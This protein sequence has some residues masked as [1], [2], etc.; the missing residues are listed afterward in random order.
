LK[1]SN[2]F[3]SSEGGLLALFSA[4]GGIDFE[5]TR[6]EVIMSRMPYPMSL[7]FLALLLGLV[8]IATQLSSSLGQLFQ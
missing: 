3:W 7:E 1:R 6:S 5:G 8:A 4:D 2:N